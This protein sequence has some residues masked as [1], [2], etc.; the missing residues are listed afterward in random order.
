MLFALGVEGGWPCS[1]CDDH[2]PSRESVIAHLNS[3]LIDEPCAAVKS[4]DSLVS[5]SFL[6]VR[7]NRVRESFLEPDQRRPGYL[8]TSRDNLV[9]S[10]AVIPVNEFG[11]SDEHFLRIAA[12]QR[13]RAAKRSR[14]DPATFQPAAWHLY[15]TADAAVPVPITTRSYF[16]IMGHVSYLHA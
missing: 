3:G 14:I 7:G 16:L 8:R 12:S 6:C 10:H 4:G 13:T 1:G 15:A 9:R 11:G 5:E 2:V